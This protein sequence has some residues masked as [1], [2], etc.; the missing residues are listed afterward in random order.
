MASGVQL[1]HDR[2]QI[3]VTLDSGPTS[4]LCRCTR[5]KLGPSDAGFFASAPMCGSGRTKG[6]TACF[7]CRKCGFRPLRNRFS[8]GFGNSGKYVQGKPGSGRIIDGH[9]V[10]PRVHDSREEFNIAS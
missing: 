8:F 6:D 9:K 5:P 1:F 4:N 10:C 3:S 7:R 2:Q